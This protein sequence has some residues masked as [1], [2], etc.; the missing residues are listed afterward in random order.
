MFVGRLFRTRVVLVQCMLRDRLSFRWLAAIQIW[1]LM[2]L[3][4]GAAIAIHDAI[5]SL[6]RLQELCS[7]TCFL[8]S[9]T[10]SARQD[11]IH[12]GKVVLR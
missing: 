12:V 10:S 3:S 2:I 9:R 1:R 11:T 4:L 6:V 5:G 8:T 7:H